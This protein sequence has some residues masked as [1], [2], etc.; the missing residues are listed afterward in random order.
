[1]SA[2]T[3]NSQAGTI[4]NRSGGIFNA[5]VSN[6]MQ[7]LPGGANAFNNEGTFNRS[8]TGTTT[9]QTSTTAV[10]FNNL[11]T[12]VVN[13][14]AGT[15]ALTSGGSNDGSMVVNSPAFLTLGGNF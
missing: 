15:L 6:V 8:G 5:T 4:N 9:F 13:V 7:G 12:G 10:S 14:T 3:I 1:W 2:G 11:S